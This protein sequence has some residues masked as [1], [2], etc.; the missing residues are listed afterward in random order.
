[1]AL[2]ENKTLILQQLR[3]GR[4]DQLDEIEAWNAITAVANSIRPPSERKSDQKRWADEYVF[5]LG[6]IYTHYTGALPGFT[7]CQAETRFERFARA[8]ME[9]VHIHVSRNL[10]KSAIRR[11]NAKHNPQFMQH[12]GGW[13]AIHAD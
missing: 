9:D 8:V 2:K 11:L 13:R 12:L 6:L 3:N 5:A 1:M 4:R 7:N 10:V